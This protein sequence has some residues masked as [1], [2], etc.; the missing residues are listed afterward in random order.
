[1]TFVTAAV[2]AGLIYVGSNYFNIK[3][4]ETGKKTSTGTLMGHLQYPNV[5]VLDNNTV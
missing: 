2:K 5:V 3:V 4:N 1:M